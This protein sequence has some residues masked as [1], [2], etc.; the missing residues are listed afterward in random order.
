MNHKLY[1]T[2]DKDA[3]HSILDGNGE[4]VLALC[5]VC[6]GAEGTLPTCCPGRRLT[7]KEEEEIYRGELDFGIFGGDPETSEIGPGGA[8]HLG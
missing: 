8:I 4:V 2:G 3:P 7:P 1:E 6:G 5:R